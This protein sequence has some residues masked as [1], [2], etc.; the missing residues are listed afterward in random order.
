MDLVKRIGKEAAVV[1][2]L[3]TLKVNDMIDVGDNELLYYAKNGALWTIVSDAVNYLDT[4]QSGFLNGD[5][6]YFVD[7]TFFNTSMYALF[8]KTGLGSRLVDLAED[9]PLIN[10]NKLIA[11]SV[12]TGVLKVGGKLGIQMLKPSMPQLNILTN[13]SSLWN[14]RA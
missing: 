5:Y 7:E 9:I 11:A 12:A 10:S 4:M 13:V 8:E 1:F 6:I 2:I 14:N 3:E